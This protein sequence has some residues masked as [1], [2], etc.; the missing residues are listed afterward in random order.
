MLGGDWD[1][2]RTFNGKLPDAALL[3]KYVPDRPVILRRY[4]GHVA[5]ANSKALKLAGINAEDARTR[6][7]ASS[8]ASPTAR[9]RPACCATTP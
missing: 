8:T 6:R 3:D 2:D 5:V 1:H 4:D 9:S 7:A